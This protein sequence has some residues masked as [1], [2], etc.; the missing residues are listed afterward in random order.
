MIKKLIALLILVSSFYFVGATGVLAS[1][2]ISVS[3]KTYN[4]S[5]TPI[6]TTPHTGKSRGDQISF[7]HGDGQTL[8]FAFYAVNDTIR[9]E[10][11]GTHEFKV[12]SRMSVSVIYDVRESGEVTHHAVVFVDSNRKIL[13]V[14]YVAK[15]GF[16]NTDG[17]TIT[18]PPNM[19]WKA[20]PW[21]T[22][23]NK[24]LDVAVNENRVY[25]AQ[26]QVETEAAS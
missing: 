21:L 8:G 6:V 10:L 26:Y 15:D 13:K 16:A 5:G 20:T 2:N 3:V 19:E 1:N 11:P 25:Y 14:Q 18:P 7:T 23:D 9:P 17:I 24:G 4:G 12:M 22:L